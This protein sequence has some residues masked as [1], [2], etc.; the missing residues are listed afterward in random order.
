MGQNAIFRYIIVSLLNVTNRLEQEGDMLSR[1]K[2]K[3]IELETNIS[4]AAVVKDWN[5]IRHMWLEDVKTSVNN[6]QLVTQLLFLEKSIN[7]DNLQSP[8][9]G[10]RSSFVSTLS[11]ANVSKAGIIGS[12]LSLEENLKWDA[13]RPDWK[14]V[15]P[16][17]VKYSVGTFI[18][19]NIC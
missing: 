2:Q 16:M 9:R 5:K 3:T 17:W 12:L 18:Y 10:V 8:W 19:E 13:V 7:N 14:N 15:R 1:V 4:F 11:E 6:R